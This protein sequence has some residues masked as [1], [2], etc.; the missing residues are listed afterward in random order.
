M[1]VSVG[2]VAASIVGDTSYGGAG[3]S[4]SDADEGVRTVAFGSGAAHRICADCA[5]GQSARNE[6]SGQRYF[7]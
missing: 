1:A 2:W 3:V 7:D 6:K 5:E 4:A